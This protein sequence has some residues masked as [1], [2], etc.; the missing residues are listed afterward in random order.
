MLPTDGRLLALLHL[1]D[2]LF[3]TGAFAHSDGLEAATASGAVATAADL[4]DWMDVCLD[5]S[6]GRLEAPAVWLGGQAWSAGRWEDLEALDQEVQALR[7]SSTA[8]AAGRAMG[9]RLLKTWLD[10]HPD[11]NLERAATRRPAY[12]YPVAFGIAG[13]A[14][15][16]E[17]RAAVAGFFYSRLAGIASSAM[18]LM[19]IGQGEAHRLLAAVLARVP[20]AVEALGARLA[21]GE[22]LSSFAPAFDIAVMGQQYVHSR[23]F[24]S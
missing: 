20:S 11:P 15:G 3:P 24:L 21:R 9:S 2:S 5:E 8:R 12:I 10:I 23:L 17:P 6:L 13:G 16:L 4:R 22:A 18:R 7:P 14:I 19:P 1:C